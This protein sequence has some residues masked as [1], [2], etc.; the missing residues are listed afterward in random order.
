MG[1]KTRKKIGEIGGA[2]VRPSAVNIGLEEPVIAMTSES[3]T[4]QIDAPG[5]AGKGSALD[6]ATSPHHKHRDIGWI[7]A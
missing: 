4:A 1:C 6:T 3:G 2:H 7:S 5:L